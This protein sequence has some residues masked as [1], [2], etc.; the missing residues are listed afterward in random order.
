MKINYKILYCTNV[1]EP[2]RALIAAFS[3]GLGIYNTRVLQR[4]E[5]NQHW[6]DLG[7]VVEKGDSSDWGTN[8][9]FSSK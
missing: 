3:L 9:Y 5:D 2:K 4:L 8:D 6:N 7:F 1:I